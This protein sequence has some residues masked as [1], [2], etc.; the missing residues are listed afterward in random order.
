MLIGHAGDLPLIQLCPH[1]AKASLQLDS[2]RY[3]WGLLSAE[4]ENETGYQ[5]RLISIARIE[6]RGKPV[7]KG[8]QLD[9]VKRQVHGITNW[10]LSRKT[11]NCALV[12][13]LVGKCQNRKYSAVL[14]SSVLICKAAVLSRL[15]L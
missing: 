3:S 5:L 14:V 15:E 4:P 8:A 13:V 2:A 12:K 7:A 6:T 11:G 1:T 10:R 9:F